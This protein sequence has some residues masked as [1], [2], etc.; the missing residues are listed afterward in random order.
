M[1]DLKKDTVTLVFSLMTR[2]DR[3]KK[4]SEPGLYLVNNLFYLNLNIIQVY[5]SVVK[6]N[7]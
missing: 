1:N 4:K 5:D 7:S 3:H 6:I 2:V